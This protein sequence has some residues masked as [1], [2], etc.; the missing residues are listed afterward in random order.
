MSQPQPQRVNADD[1]DMDESERVLYQGEPFTGEVVETDEDG[2][3]IRLNNY[4]DGKEEGAQREWFNDGMLRSEYHAT[5]GLPTGE[6]REWHE[7]GR[8]ARRQEFDQYGHLRVREDWD[9][10]GVAD[11]EPMN[12]W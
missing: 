7:N 6:S 3:V 2:V 10:H 4:L 1:T 5:G 9:E 12:T 8:L 11:G